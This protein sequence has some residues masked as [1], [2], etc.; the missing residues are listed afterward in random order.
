MTKCICSKNC[1]IISM[2][3]SCHN[4]IAFHSVI[5]FFI[6]SGYLILSQCVPAHHF[7]FH[8]ISYIAH[9]I[10]ETNSIAFECVFVANGKGKFLHHLVFQW[11]RNTFSFIILCI[12]RSLCINVCMH[13]VIF[14]R[15]KCKI[16]KINTYTHFACMHFR[17][18]AFDFTLQPVRLAIFVH[19][20]NCDHFHELNKFDWAQS[21]FFFC[22]SIA[23]LPADLFV[24]SFCFLL[25][26][27]G[28]RMKSSVNS[29]VHREREK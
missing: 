10:C 9:I 6:H 21:F 5:F 13:K 4:L 3:S 17:I 12:H 2:L 29:L 16:R 7:E 24:E 25:H 20:T 18:C 26:S 28:V 15:E 19:K 23:C 11:K 1:C 14:K 22:Y 8:D 27:Y